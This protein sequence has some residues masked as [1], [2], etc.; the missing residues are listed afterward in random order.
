MPLSTIPSD[1]LDSQAQYYGFKNRIINGDMRID[2]RNNGASVTNP[3]GYVPDRWVAVVTGTAQRVADA[4]SG[5]VNSL[6]LNGSSGFPQCAQRIESANAVDL[7]GSFVT[8]SF[9]AKRVSGTTEL[10]VQLL[11]PN[12]LDTWSSSTIIQEAVYTAP[13]I[14]AWIK[15]TITS[16]AV[17]PTNAANGL[18][19]LIYSPSGASETRITGVQLE[20]GTTATSFDYVDYGRQ[21]M[22]CQRYYQNY[23]AVY[24]APLVSGVSVGNFPLPVTMRA[25]PTLASNASGFTAVITQPT[26]LNMYAATAGGYT[27]TANSEL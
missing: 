25:S 18:G 8:V 13:A 6:S 12:A 7:V 19:V 15:Y 24:L 5:F 20:K 11:Y 1:G 16:N 17:M 26:Y 2:Q 10:R 9:W 27:L 3:N 4:P 14:G 23:P 22:Q 21:L